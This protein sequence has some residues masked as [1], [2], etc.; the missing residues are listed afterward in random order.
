MTNFVG[1]NQIE[2]I[3]GNIILRQKL[4]EILGKNHIENFDEFFNSFKENYKL[5]VFAFRQ[6]IENVDIR[7]FSRCLYFPQYGVLRE[8]NQI[9]ILVFLPI[10]TFEV[11]TMELY[12]C[13]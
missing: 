5:M 3:N 12:K 7:L 11:T 4:K 10:G 1:I 2:R 13:Q 9:K 8:D 6:E